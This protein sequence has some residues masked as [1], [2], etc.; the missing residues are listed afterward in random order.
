MFLVCKTS[1]KLIYL[2]IFEI[3]AMDA[4]LDFVKS[5]VRWKYEHKLYLKQC[6]NSNICIN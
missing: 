5:K 2:F 6:R 4:V 1:Y 3:V